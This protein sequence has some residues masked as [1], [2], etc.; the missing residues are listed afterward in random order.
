MFEL[1]TIFTAGSFQY[2][3]LFI[4]FSKQNDMWEIPVLWS[5]LEIVQIHCCTVLPEQLVF[6][7]C[8]FLRLA[9]SRARLLSN[10]HL[11][12]DWDTWR[13]IFTEV[14]SRRRGQPWDQTCLN[15]GYAPQSVRGRGGLSYYFHMWETDEVA[16]VEMT[17]RPSVLIFI[18]EL[19]SQA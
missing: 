8:K 1:Y 6:L 12:F 11:P 17:Y 10:C 14:L 7:I 16:E 5:L 9:S 15:E 13:C 4:A 19:P 3:T 18:S 2:I